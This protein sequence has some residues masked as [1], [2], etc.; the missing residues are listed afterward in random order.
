MHILNAIELSFTEM[1]TAENIKKDP[2]KGEY[3][4]IKEIAQ[5]KK[6]VSGFEAFSNRERKAK[7]SKNTNILRRG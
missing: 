6:L 5:K 2:C 3:Q 1:I 7:K 4:R